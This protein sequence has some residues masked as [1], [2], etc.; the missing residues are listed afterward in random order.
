VIYVNVEAVK[1]EGRGVAGGNGWHDTDSVGEAVAAELHRF[2]RM[3]DALGHGAI[4]T[5]EITVS[6]EASPRRT[7]GNRW[8]LP[9]KETV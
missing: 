6:P 7:R 4:V 8:P 2:H 3:Y 9:V 1:S 5:Y